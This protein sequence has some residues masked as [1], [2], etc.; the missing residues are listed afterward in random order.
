M[1]DNVDGLIGKNGVHLKSHGRA[2]T[3]YFVDE[4]EVFEVEY[5]LGMKGLIIYFDSFFKKQQLEPGKELYIKNA[6][7]EWANNTG[8]AIEFT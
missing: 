6:I 5:E 3:I 4:L 8:N 2:G 7:E 1:E